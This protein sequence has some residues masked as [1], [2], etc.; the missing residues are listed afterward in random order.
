MI[1]TSRGRWLPLALL[2]AASTNARADGTATTDVGAKRVLLKSSGTWMYVEHAGDPSPA[3]AIPDQSLTGGVE[4]MLDPGGKRD[5]NP[6]NV[7]K[8]ADAPKSL[9]DQLR[10]VDRRL[11]VAVGVG[12][13][14]LV[15]ATIGILLFFLA[16]QPAKRR[17]LLRR[18]LTILESGTKEQ[19][20]LKEAE[21]LLNRA[22]EAGLRNADI[23][24]AYFARAY[25][26]AVRGIEDAALL[27]LAI[28][29]IKKADRSDPAV[30]YLELW[31]RVKQK[32]YDEAVAL[33]DA[34]QRDL[35][36]F[37][38]G[39]ALMSIA[40]FNLATE[41][42][43]KKEVE[44]A[45]K[46]FDRVRALG[47]H[48][49]RLPASSGNHHTTLGIV[50]LF[51]NHVDEAEKY[52]KTAL[53]QRSKDKTSVIEAD[54]GLLLCRWK[55][56]DLVG[57]HDDL[58]DLVARVDSDLQ[59]VVLRKRREGRKDDKADDVDETLTDVGFLKRN[60]FL[61]HAVSLVHT[62]SGR[63]EKASLP[64]DQRDELERRL[65]KVV[66]VDA[67]MP[68][69]KLLLG[70][71]DYYL[72]HDSLK[73][74]AIKRLT[75]AGIDVPEV[76]LLVDRE[77]KIMQAEQNLLPTFFAM[78]KGYVANHEVPKQMRQELVDALQRFDR[79]RSLERDL[80][81]GDT[82]DETGVTLAGLQ[83][84]G[85]LL[86]QRVERIVKPVMSKQGAE[87]LKSLDE[88]LGG[89][90]AAAEAIQGG[91][92]KLE[93]HELQLMVSTGE[94]LLREESSVSDADGGQRR[95]DIPGPSTVVKRLPSRPVSQPVVPPVSS[96]PMPSPPVSQPVVPPAFSRPMP[97]PPSMR[98]AV[99]PASSRPMPSPPVSR[100]AVP[101]ASS[102]PMP[103]PPSMRPV[104]PPP[105]S[106]PV[107]PP[108]LRPPPP[109]TSN[110]ES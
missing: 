34:S 89:M 2:L 63:A 62:W 25:A 85:A 95:A 13:G 77:N 103:S 19:G 106:R 28:A 68:D 60:V 46:S 78:V 98:P 93:E 10:A 44:A 51:D 101:P 53:D 94:F 30:L 105:S 40:S 74:S 7:R 24:E 108:P 20:Q 41:L 31:T 22:I 29:D 56:Q 64:R 87:N 76:N 8:L 97:S 12:A 50:S 67:N 88:M 52:F 86:T 39:K 92:K 102:R 82:V 84:R 14:L 96:R 83:A 5:A 1:N 32:K 72:F 61:W 47:V 73:A 99:P 79:F 90:K 55:R 107:G 38:H 33:C 110:R 9:V 11:L 71:I 70:L 100:P 65:D 54:L 42:W 15:L 17:K 6:S 59:D 81:I 48:V 27:D 58:G 109:P 21:D 104:A 43:K 57:V 3:P 45:V 16:V 37:E 36:S 18:A 75:N 80:T 35:E 23:K 49:D 91:A 4:S 66:A 69:P 26:F